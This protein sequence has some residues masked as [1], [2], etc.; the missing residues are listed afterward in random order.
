MTVLLAVATLALA[1]AKFTAKIGSHSVTLAWTQSTSPVVTGNSIYRAPGACPQPS[2]AFAKIFT[3]SSPISTYT[4]SGLPA[5]TAYCYSVSVLGCNTVGC[6]NIQESTG[7][8]TVSV[9]YRFRYLNFATAALSKKISLRWDPVTTLPVRSYRVYDSSDGTIFS[10]LASGVKSTYYV[11][12]TLTTGTR[13]Y[14]VR[15]V[16]TSGQLTPPSNVVL[17]TLP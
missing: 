9:G 13:Y 6:T 2:S 1:Q 4:D 11:D 3:S 7:N 16:T 12:R 15:A 10:S 5:S 17:V 14:E 8:P